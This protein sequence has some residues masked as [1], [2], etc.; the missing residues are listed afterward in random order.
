MRGS[1]RGILPSAIRRPRPAPAIEVHVFPS[2]D[3]GIV[4]R[5]DAGTMTLIS[6]LQETEPPA[7]E[8]CQ[9]SGGFLFIG[10]TASI[11]KVDLA[12]MEP[13]ADTTEQGGQNWAM[14][15]GADG[16]LLTGASNWSV[17][18]WDPAD[19]IPLA[20][21][22][23]DHSATVYGIVMGPDGF[24]Y[25]GAGGGEIIKRDPQTL[26]GIETFDGPD[27]DPWGMA[28]GPDGHLYV[29]LFGQ[30]AKIDVTGTEMSV[31]DA[32]EGIPAGEIVWDVVAGG[33]FIFATD[34]S[35]TV[36]KIDPSDMSGAGTYT[37]H[38]DLVYG[39]SFGADGFLYTASAD[40][41]VHRIDPASMT[42]A[43]THDVQS[44]LWAVH[45]AA[46]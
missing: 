29:G 22:V 12:T 41:E 43:G 40:G 16:S 17:A 34:Q 7:A 19:L 13:V 24:V 5:I 37:G 31:I 38:G 1:G 42:N 36:H 9:A 35:D 30:V 10:R 45:A 32:Y 21:P 20:G 15:E 26:A 46:I 8:V 4:S 3:N 44:T 14:D 28:F 25:S 11:I 27:G 39:L 33:G 6:E 18:R 2:P 23:F